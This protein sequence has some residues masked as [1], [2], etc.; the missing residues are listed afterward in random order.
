MS[1]MAKA[2][3]GL[4]LTQASIRETKARRKAQMA[5][6]RLTHEREL[7][8]VALDQAATLQRYQAGPQKPIQQMVADVLAEAA[9]IEA[10]LSTG[11]LLA[12][13]RKTKLNK[14]IVKQRPPQYTPVFP[15]KK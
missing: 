3:G 1:A 5:E 11:K 9:K 8:R 15:V 6:Q 14:K 13:P 4:N 7:R 12:K 2:L 10:Y